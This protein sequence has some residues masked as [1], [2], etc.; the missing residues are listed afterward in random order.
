MKNLDCHR[1]SHSFDFPPI[2]SHYRELE[3]LGDI[4]IYRTCVS[5]A[6]HLNV[7][8]I[9]REL[10]TNITAVSGSQLMN[11]ECIHL[12]GVDEELKLISSKSAN[13]RILSLFSEDSFLDAK[14]SHKMEKLTHLKVNSESIFRINALE[15]IVGCKVN[16]KHQ[17]TSLEM[18]AWTSLNFVEIL[19]RNSP[20]LHKLTVRFEHPSS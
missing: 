12:N 16:N 13:V 3:S 14:A 6:L 18:N 11:F 19:N 1:S 20:M 8:D 2:L 5:F 17:I 9:E 4:W 15:R 7:A 10:F